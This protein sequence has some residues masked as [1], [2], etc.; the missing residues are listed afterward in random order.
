MISK[1]HEFVFF[2][3]PKAA[4]RSIDFAIKKYYVNARGRTAWLFATHEQE[5]IAHHCSYYHLKNARMGLPNI[6]D[7]YK[8]AFVSLFICVRLCLC[9]FVHF[10]CVFV[11]VLCLRV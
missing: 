5:K 8:F 10:V 11:Y 6:N 4:G 7:Y 1:K 9:I 2:R 3:V